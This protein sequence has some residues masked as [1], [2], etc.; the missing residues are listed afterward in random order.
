MILTSHLENLKNINSEEYK[1]LL[2]ILNPFAPHITEELWEECNFEPNIESS[3]WPTFNEKDLV[4]NEVE[5]AVQI[6]SKIVGRTKICTT[7]SQEE[8]EAKVKKEFEP[9]FANKQIIKSILIPSRLINFI[10]K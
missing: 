4:Q 10:I 1:I 3:P 2:R 6:N 7:A 8:I 9:K 5:I